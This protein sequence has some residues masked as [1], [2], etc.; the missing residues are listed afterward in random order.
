VLAHPH[1][2]TRRPRGCLFEY[3]R[4][5]WTRWILAAL[6]LAV[7]ALTHATPLDTVLVASAATTKRNAGPQRAAVATPAAL[8]NTAI[9]TASG[10]AP[11]QSGFVHYFVITDRDGERE[12]QVGLELPG[13]RIAWSFPGL[14]VVVSPFVRSGVIVSKAG[15]YEVDHLYGIR[16]FSDERAMQ[17]LR[18]ELS[19]RIA[20]LVE[21]NTPYCDEQR[22]SNGACM[23]CLGFV[24]RVLYPPRDNGTLP[25]MPDDFRNARTGVYTTEDLLLYLAGVRVDAPHPAQMKHIEALTL[26]DDMRQ[27]LVRIATENESVRAEVAAQIKPVSTASPSVSTT[28]PKPRAVRSSADLPKRVLQRRRS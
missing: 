11:N 3:A 24:L 7:G 10:T 2:Q 23:S 1:T 25:A 27:Q 18:D 16:P 26:P 8:P 13:D 12:T 17:V 28:S 6:G 4:R 9:V 19:L 5:I 21:A 15:A 20:P 22:P 14:G